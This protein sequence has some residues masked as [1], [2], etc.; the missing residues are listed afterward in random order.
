[1]ITTEL[2][3]YQKEAVELALPHDGFALFMEQRTGK[4]LT[5][6]AIVSERKPSALL[7]ICPKRA[8]PV[9]HSEVEK[10]FSGMISEW[11]VINFEQILAKRKEFLKRA[12]KWENVFIIVDESHRIKRRGSKQSRV[13]RTLGGYARWRLALTGT[14]IA[15]GI[16]DAWAQFN[17]LDPS[18][19]GPWL[20]FSNRYL[21]YGGFK[22]KKI[23]GY[24]SL[25]EFNELFHKFSYRKT[26]AEVKR[27][28]NLPVPKIRRSRILFPLRNTTYRIYRE[29]EKTLETTVNRVRVQTRV[30]VASAM[31]LQ[32]IT[33]GY[34]LRGEGEVPDG[35]SR[36]LF[37]GVEK[38]VALADLI[39]SGRPGKR[40]I[41]V[42]RFTHELTEIQAR[43]GLMGLTTK[44]IAGGE[45]FNGKF[46]TDV[47]VLQVASGVSI[48]L[49]TADSII[50]YSWDYSY[51]NYEQTKFRVLSY[52]KRQVNYYYLIAE[53]TI[54]EKIYEATTRKKN[55]AKLICD[56]YRR[57]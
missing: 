57:T 13:I 55:F 41:I 22:N 17:F 42:A 10:H 2:R 30:V 35:K 27:A 26:L 49:S 18:I 56:Y 25:D 28:A 38:M 12:K 37:V 16:Q 44:L 34:L 3:P 54:D 45:E 39:R 50:F 19:F 15:Q 4:T 1:M 52:D 51:I 40:F 7:V 47:V 6:L 53:G 48:D 31:K 32:Q 21:T 14:P 43:L 11:S 24:R 5:A 29:L 36:V 46:E 9:W 8:I 20:D 33:G 23:V